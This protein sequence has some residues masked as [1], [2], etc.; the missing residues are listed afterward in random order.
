MPSEASRAV[1]CEGLS[2]T[3]TDDFRHLDQTIAAFMQEMP[4]AYR[5][6]VGSTVDPLL[7]MAHLL[8]HV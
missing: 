7:Y 4:R 3:E 5:D 6:L 2:P 1:N 8:P